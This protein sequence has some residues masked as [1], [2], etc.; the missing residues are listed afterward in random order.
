[1]S[2]KIYNASNGIAL[3][4]CLA[5]HILHC[6]QCQ[7]F[8]KDKPATLARCCL[9]GSILWKRENVIASP[10]RESPKFHCSKDEL[11]REMKYK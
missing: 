3:D 5:N 2:K 4:D 1:M 6:K 10:S 9:E 8:D 7:Q 11:R